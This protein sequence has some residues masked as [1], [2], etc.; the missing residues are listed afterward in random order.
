MQYYTCAFLTTVK[1]NFFS[2][3]VSGGESNHIPADLT[4]T[5]SK[6]CRISVAIEKAR[7]PTKNK[8]NIKQENS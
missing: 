7:I 1:L 6:F 3:S 2:F 5:K 4:V 8:L